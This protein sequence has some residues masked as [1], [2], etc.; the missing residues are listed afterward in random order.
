MNVNVLKICNHLKC[1]YYFFLGDR[2]M[3]TTICEYSLKFEKGCAGAFL[4]PSV[5]VCMNV[6][7]VMHFDHIH[8]RK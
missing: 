6:G 1:N 7:L 3:L 8:L 4:D 5:G 2:V